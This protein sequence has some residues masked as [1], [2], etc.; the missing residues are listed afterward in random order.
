M[1]TKRNS[2]EKAKKHYRFFLLIFDDECFVNFTS[3]IDLRNKL[4]NHKSGKYYETTKWKEKA[5]YGEE[6]EVYLLEETDSPISSDSAKNLLLAWILY[7]KN[8]QGYKICNTELD[9]RGTNYPPDILHHYQR[10]CNQNNEP[11]FIC[12]VDFEKKRHAPYT[13]RETDKNADITEDADGYCIEEIVDEDELGN[14]E[15]VSSEE[16]FEEKKPRLDDVIKGI[17]Q[18]KVK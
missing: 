18:Q 5:T 3:A 17:E 16:K 11:K 12:K 6:F 10:I 8:K 7:Y 1:S 15:T 2:K 14:T 9:N 13:V 4:Q